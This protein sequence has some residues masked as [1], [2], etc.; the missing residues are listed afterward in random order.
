M[1]S[2]FASRADLEGRY[3]PSNVSTWADLAADGNGTSI[4]NRIDLA[5]RNADAWIYGYLRKGKYDRALPTVIDSNGNIPLELTNA[6]VMYAGYWIS[7]ARGT[8]DYD[9]D[10]KP[11]SHLYVDYLQARDMM[12]M[13]ASGTHFLL[14]VSA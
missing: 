2:Y 9:K 8:A 14:D 4:A 12:E 10:G 1:A 6:A 11:M 13:I 3:D 7:T 5:L